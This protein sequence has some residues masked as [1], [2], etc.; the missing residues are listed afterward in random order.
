[1][2]TKRETLRCMTWLGIAAVL[3]AASIF[4]GG[5]AT[6][7][8]AQKPDRGDSQ[9]SAALAA[10]QP[11]TEYHIGPGDDLNIVVFN[12]P[13]LT[14]TVPVRPDGLISMPLVESMQASGRTPGELG[15][16]IEKKLS[17]YV[18]SPQV[19]V[20]VTRFVGTYADQI[21]V[22]G[23]A[24]HPQALPFKNG[25]KLIDVMIQVG[26][27]GQFAAGNRAHVLRTE[28][29]KEVQ[30]RVRLNDLVNNGD[31]K[32]NIDMRPGDILIIPQSRF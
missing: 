30:I 29:G 12:Q 11:A 27:L 2:M 4:A 9:G 10:E 22:V 7:S 19:N 15:R 1:M 24:V 32:Q 16:A 3:M 8:A 6:D 23:E 5:C 28:R 26:G 13:E 17:E 21:R 20:I 31:T 25:M 18:R 14:V